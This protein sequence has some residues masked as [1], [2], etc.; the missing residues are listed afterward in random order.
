MLSK[1]RKNRTHWTRTRVEAEDSLTKSA[2][3][4]IYA[5]LRTSSSNLAKHSALCRIQYSRSRA[6]CKITQIKM[7]RHRRVQSCFLTAKNMFSSHLAVPKTVKRQSP[8]HIL[9]E[10]RCCRKWVILKPY[11][12]SQFKLRLRLLHCFKTFSTFIKVAHATVRYGNIT[13]AHDYS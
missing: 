11:R 1:R 2:S 10:D 12:W 3:L 9:L 7:G 13:Q 4:E 6:A 8:L 5:L